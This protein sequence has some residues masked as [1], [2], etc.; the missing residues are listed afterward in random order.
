MIVMVWVEMAYGWVKIAYGCV[1][2]LYA[3]VPVV[4]GLGRCGIRSSDGKRMAGVRWY[5]VE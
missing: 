1:E 5:M 2:I 3:C 4:F